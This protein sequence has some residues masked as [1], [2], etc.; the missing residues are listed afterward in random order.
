MGMLMHFHQSIGML[1]H[2]HQPIGM[3][4]YG[5]GG[6]IQGNYNNNRIVTLRLSTIHLGNPSWTIYY[7]HILPYQTVASRLTMYK[8]PHQGNRGRYTMYR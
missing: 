2:F 4:D 6:N 1:M 8:V 5:G 7:V 3:K